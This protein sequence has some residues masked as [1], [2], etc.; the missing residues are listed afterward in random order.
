MITSSTP[1]RPV[2]RLSQILLLPAFA[3]ALLASMWSAVFYQIAQDRSAAHNEAVAHSQAMAHTLAEQVSHTLRQADHA[4]QLFK[5][6]F[7]ET[8]GRLRLPEFVRRNGLLDS[9]L[10]ARLELPIA[11]V[12]RNG[13]VLDSAHAYMASNVADQAYFQSLAS[14]PPEASI[15]TTPVLEARTSKWHVQVARRLNDAKGAFAGL[16]IIMIDPAV[17]IDDYDRL[18][19]D[20]KGVLLLVSRDTG[21]AM[22]RVGENMFSSDKIDFAAPAESERA[23]NPDELVPTKPF[24]AVARIYS[25]REMPRFALMAVVG[26]AQASA[27]ARF[28]HHRTLF[29][30]ALAAATALIAA[31]MALLMEQSARLRASTEAARAAQEILRAAAEASLDAFIILKAWPGNGRRVED[32]TIVDIN[33]RGAQ[34]VGMARAQLLG[35]KACE[36]LPACRSAGFYDRYVQV[37]ESAKPLEE[38]F[39]LLQPGEAPRWLHHQ[40]VPIAGGVAITSR[41]ITARKSA[42]QEIRDNRSFLQSLIEHL[43]LLIYVKCV[44]KESFGRMLV[45][46]NA[47]ETITG[48][49]ADQVVGRRDNEAFAPEFAQRIGADDQRMLASPAVIDLPEQPFTRADGSLRHLHTISVPLFDQDGRPEYILCI[50]EDVTRR[51]AQEQALRANQAELAAVNDASP[52]GLVRSDADGNCTYVNRTFEAITGLTRAQALGDGWLETIHPGDRPAIDGARERMAATSEPFTAVVRCRH[53]QG[54][55]VWMSAKMAPIRVDGRVDG[56]VGSIEDITTLREAELALRESEARLRII[57]DTLPAMVAYLDA[58]LVY[59]FRNRAYEQEFKLADEPV[60]GRKL[61][62]M[63]GEVRFAALEPYLARVLDGETVRFEEVSMREGVERTLEVIYIPQHGDDGVSVVGFHAIRQDITAQTHEKKRLLKL[64][65][66]DALTGLANRAGFMQKLGDAMAGCDASGQLMAVMYMDI[67]HFKPVNDTHGHNVGDAL[68]KAFSG[69]LTHAL[70]ATDTVGRLGGDEFTIVME[71]LMRSEDALQ[72]A[73]KIVGAMHKPFN[74]DGVV[75]AVSTSIGVA[76]YRGGALAPEALLAQADA[77]LYQAKNDGR[78]TY[79]SAASI[80][81][82]SAG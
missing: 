23:R 15:F 68:L 47:A 32:F 27:M 42:E 53:P 31:V 30:W 10:P 70:R 17:F 52:L 45:W 54:R 37:H 50:A 4:T 1:T 41:E 19:V 28:E 6:K 75:V 14:G 46:N 61:R 59:R 21:L 36:L 39:E 34:M 13:H 66:I 16:I 77:L 76:F 74:L 62:E 48:Y 22:G 65:Q 55:I 71:K 20:D 9:V 44:R 29:L 3:L 57:A 33:E 8:G 5:L 26:L 80:T 40:I 7:E 18:N 69:R 60:N 56:Y 78:D 79:R 49:R 12:D 67:D 73:A 11:L 63:I 58:D 35:Q 51:R 38:E 72:I 24:D 25:Y 64:A 81:A 82:A 2:H 43:P